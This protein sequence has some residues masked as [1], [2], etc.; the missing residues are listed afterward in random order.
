MAKTKFDKGIETLI[1]FLEENF[2]T[3]PLWEE[4]NYSPQI[5]F[6]MIF[7]DIV[8]NSKNIEKINNDLNLPETYYLDFLVDTM[9]TDA[10]TLEQF[11]YLL[12][13]NPIKLDI[14]KKK[15]RYMYHFSV[16]SYD[17]NKIETSKLM[18]VALSAYKYLRENF[19]D[20]ANLKEGI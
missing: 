5:N 8:V 18:E 19:K 2:L 1:P 17:E 16:W 7:D 11:E 20:N 3:F 13:G 9:N 15:P 6:W 12:I 4:G 10:I 14:S